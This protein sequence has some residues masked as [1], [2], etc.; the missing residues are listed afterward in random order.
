MEIASFLIES[1]SI[2]LHASLIKSTIFFKLGSDVDDG[3][4]A[5]VDSQH[6]PIDFFH[7][8]DPH[9]VVSH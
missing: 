4:L 2:V 9:L 8:G 5:A 1:Y 3:T 6:F 7:L